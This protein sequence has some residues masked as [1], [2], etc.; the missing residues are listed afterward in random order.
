MPSLKEPIVGFLQAARRAGL[1]VSV[2]ESLDAFA[3]L[4]TVGYADRALLKETLGLVLAK[5]IPEKFVFDACFE[6]YFQRDGLLQLPPGA[7][8]PPGDLSP[9]ARLLL[10][11]DRAG[12][13]TALE[14]AAA[15]VGVG[16]IRL[17]TQ[18]GSFTQRVL[19]RM[20]VEALL[21]DIARLREGGGEGRET[22]DALERGREY[23]RAAVRALVQQALDLTAQA[24]SARW[25]DDPRNVSRFVNLERKDL[26]RMRVVV[27][28]MAKRIAARYGSNRR[29]RRRGFLDVRGTLRRN[30]GYDGVPFVTVWKRRKI[31]K[32]R[33]MVLCDVSGSVAA[34][35]QFLLLFLYSLSEVVSDI[36]SFAFSSH[37]IEVSETLE[38]MTVEDA[39]A[40]IVADIGFRSSDYGRSLR[41]FE[42]GWMDK[43]NRKTTVIIMG[44][45][46]SNFTAP[47]V[48]VMRALYERAKRVVWLNPESPWS[49]NVGDSE[50][51]RYATYCHDV[52][53]FSRLRDL[54]LLVKDLTAAR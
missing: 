40:K 51:R 23:L 44:D 7:A 18:T 34:V 13:A 48:E 52:R 3:A 15:E 25:N 37:L 49:W 2:A 45:A 30:M 35:A 33:V 19:D 10:A 27:R 46:R 38:R 29:R 53:E 8:S 36:R 41:D 9:L 17:F 39:V 42:A 12:L 32:P 1:R 14:R 24:E 28:A 4:E 6:R 31:E 11:G 26:E 43:V 5:T 50:M 20:G 47:R 16:G 54:E 21:R 22:A